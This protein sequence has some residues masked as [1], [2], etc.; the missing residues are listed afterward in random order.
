[1]KNVLVTGSTGFIA[2]HLLPTLHQH[3]YQITTCNSPEI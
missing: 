2:S 3:N 1:M